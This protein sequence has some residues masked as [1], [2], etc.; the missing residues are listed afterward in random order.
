MDVRPEGPLG[1]REKAFQGES[2]FT[3]PNP[4]FGAVFT[5]YL[6]DELKTK[7]KAR[8]DAEKKAAT[9]G[10]RRLLPDVGRRCAPRSAR[11]SRRSS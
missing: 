3:A 9:K 7:K 10:E 4:P 1:L 11:R 6:K 5:Y 8:L 2:F